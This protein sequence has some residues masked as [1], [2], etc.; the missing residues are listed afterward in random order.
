MNTKVLI[1][2][3]ATDYI[4]SKTT[5][6][7]VSLV[8]RFPK[9]DVLIRQGC[10]LH[11]NRNDCAQAAIDGKYDYLFFV[12]SDMCFSAEVLDRLIKDDKDIVGGNYNMRRFP[13]TSVLKLTD[14][15]GNLI[16]K[17]EEI[18]HDLFKVHALGTGCMLIKVSALKNIPKPWFWFGDADKPTEQCGEDIFFC[19]QCVKAGYEIWCD[20]NMSILHIGEYLY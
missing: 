11:N 6:T 2:V 8:K 3:I 19:R 7:L 13:L 4:R 10:Y 5:A 16:A 15:E 12:D 17:T 9:S 14:D 20:G 18:P 1:G